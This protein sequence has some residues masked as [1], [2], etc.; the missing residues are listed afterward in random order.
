MDRLHLLAPTRWRWGKGL[1]Y[2]KKSECKAKRSFSSVSS[3][4]G[5][6]CA[7]LTTILFPNY[8]DLESPTLTISTRRFPA[9]S[10][11]AVFELLEAVPDRGKVAP[12]QINCRLVMMSL[13]TN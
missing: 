4:N 13:I 6:Y 11:V 3:R 9:A 1:R 5:C 7:S 10:V 12:T 2:K 8:F